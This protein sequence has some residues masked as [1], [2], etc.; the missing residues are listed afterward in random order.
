MAEGSSTSWIHCFWQSV[1][2]QVWTPVKRRGH[3]FQ[4]VACYLVSREPNNWNHTHGTARGG[5]AAS[6]NH[7]AQRPTLCR[8]RIEAA[9]GPWRFTTWGLGGRGCRA[10]PD[11]PKAAQ[12]QRVCKTEAPGGPGWR[13]ALHSLRARTAGL[14]GLQAQRRQR[15]SRETC[16]SWNGVEQSSDDLRS[17][18]ANECA[19]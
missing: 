15:R 4:A 8:P 5:W 2:Q 11:A 1:K 19:K 17:R 18:L 16:L 12:P 6:R 14:P 13:R 9:A 3:S 10:W 7:A